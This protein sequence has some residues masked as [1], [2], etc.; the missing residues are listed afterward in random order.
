MRSIVSIMILSIGI[1]GCTPAKPTMSVED[2]MLACRAK[3]SKPV[4]TRVGVGVGI[5]SGGKVRPHG[6]VSVGVDL[7]SLMDPDK[8]YNDCVKRN[9]GEWPTDMKGSSS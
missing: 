2:A 4:S 6:G 3:V 5:G 7:S 1:A 8:T 9:S